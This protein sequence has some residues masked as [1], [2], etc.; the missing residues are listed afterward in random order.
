M[1]NKTTVIVIVL[2]CIFVV[3]L[4]ICNSDRNDN[5][6]SSLSSDSSISIISSSENDNSSSNFENSSSFNN[7][8]TNEDNPINTEQ[9]WD[10][11]IA[12][13]FAGGSGTESD[14]Y[15]I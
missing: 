14:P 6:L 3:G 5:I 4:S 15:L 7:D 12:T 1:K 11:S 10:G 13:E 9:V 8:D 2:I